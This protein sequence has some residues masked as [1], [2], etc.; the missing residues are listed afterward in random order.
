VAVRF[1]LKIDDI[2]GESNDSKHK[3]EIEVESYSFGATQSGTFATGAGGAAG[4]AQLSDF[5]FTTPQSVASPVLFL[6]CASGKHLKE[7]V[8]TAQ[9]AG[10]IGVDYYKLTMTDCIVTSFQEGGLSGDGVVT[11]S[12]SLSYGKIEVAYSRQT[13]KGGL[14]S[15]VTAVWDVKASKGA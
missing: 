6:S 12:L 9:R 10:K 1:F 11:E 4:R 14:D 5:S 8:L 2:K 3:G 15:P 7:A 13:P